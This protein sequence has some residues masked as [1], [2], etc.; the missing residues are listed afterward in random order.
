V[1]EERQTTKEEGRKEEDKQT[2]QTT[3]E[4]G[5]KEEDKQTFIFTSAPFCLSFSL[6]PSSFVVYLPSCTR[7]RH[8]LSKALVYCCSLV[9]RRF[10][11][12]MSL[13]LF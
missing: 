8:F 3:K 9:L 12:Y 2:F 4:E 1:K 6:F 10:D 7:R 11:E 5:R 13:D